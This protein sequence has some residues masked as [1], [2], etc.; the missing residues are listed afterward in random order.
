MARMGDRNGAYR[1]S[2]RRPEEN[3]PLGRTMSRW[4]DNIKMGFSRTGTKIYGLNLS[5]LSIGTGGGH[6]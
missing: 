6:L 5:G 1:V 3:R 2:V 4:K